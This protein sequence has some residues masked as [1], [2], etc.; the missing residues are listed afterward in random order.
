M[1][2]ISQAQ[3]NLGRDFDFGGSARQGEI[4]LDNVEAIMIKYAVAFIEK[5]KATITKKGKIDTGHLSDIKVGTLVQEGTKYSLTIGYDKSNPASEYYDFQNKGVKG[6][7]SNQPNS[8]YKF[9]T[10]SVSPKF[11]SAIMAW[12]LRHPNY[13]RNE[14]QRKGLTGLQA[15][16]KSLA[17]VVNKTTKIKSLAEATAKS[18]KK[19]GLKRIGF[20]DDNLKVFGTEFQQQMAHALGTDVAISIKQQFKGN[21]NNNN[22]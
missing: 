11:V 9:R 1:P 3:A 5:A 10:L 22:K 13:I 7:K 21:G 6:I 2:S 19:K 20:F 12:Y 16:R 15:K 14:D 18:I 8:P 17:K 4:A